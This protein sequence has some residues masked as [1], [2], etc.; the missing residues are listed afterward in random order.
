MLG[1]EPS[2]L[3]LEPGQ[4]LARQL[5]QGLRGRILAGELAAGVRLPASRELARLLGISRNTVT[6]AYEQLLAEGFLDSRPGDGTYVAPVTRALAAPEAT[7]R[8]APLPL[9][10]VPPGAPGAFR[11]G[12]PA[13]GCC[14]RPGPWRP[15]KIPAIAPRGWPC[16]VVGRSCRESRWMGQGWWWSS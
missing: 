13:P 14:W 1:F 2:G 15:W 5:Y 9:A 3:L 7:T 8:A 12:L 16:R 4:G 10:S 11:V 6:A